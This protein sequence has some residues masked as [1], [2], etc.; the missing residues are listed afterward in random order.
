MMKNAWQT[1]EKDLELAREIIHQHYADAETDE[2]GFQEMSALLDG[3]IQIHRADWVIEM[4]EAF[5]EKYG[6]QEGR[7]ISQRVMT[8]LLTQGHDIH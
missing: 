8:A 1:K 2:V 5:E 4:E 7:V 3:D 6:S